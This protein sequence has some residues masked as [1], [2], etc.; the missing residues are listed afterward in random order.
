VATSSEKSSK[1]VR[2]LHAT[3]PE[4]VRERSSA[5]SDKPAKRRPIRSGLRRFFGLK[6]WKPFRVVGRVLSRFLIPPYFKNSWRELQMVTWPDRRT[7][8]RLTYAVIIFSII[9]GV[10]V[11][12]VDFGLDKLFKKVILHI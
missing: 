3:A 12:I 5:A 11:A 8:L 2:K 9:F 4:T 6:M 1:K 10:L 7:T